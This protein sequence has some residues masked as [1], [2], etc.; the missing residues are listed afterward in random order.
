MF[1]QLTSGEANRGRVVLGDG[2][3]GIFKS[4]RA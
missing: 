3:A 2:Y 4:R 1:E